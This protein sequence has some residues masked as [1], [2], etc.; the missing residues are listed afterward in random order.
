[1]T[2]G[3]RRES[4]TICGRDVRPSE[5]VD[6][7]LQV[8]ESYF[9]TA[10]SIPVHA[11]R[12]RR[13]GPT[14]LVTGAVH[15]DEINGTGIVRELML[16]EPFELQSGSLVLV[17]VVNLPGFERHSRYMPDRRDLNRS[18]PG[19]PEG[20]LARRYAH[21][22]FGELVR[23]CDYAIDLHTPAVRRTNFPN[24]RA[25]LKD[26]D[27]ARIAFAFG[28]GLVVNGK[29]PKGSL[30]REAGK[31]G[32]PTIVLEAGEALKFEPTVIEVGVQGVR[33][34]LIEL[35]MVEGTPLRPL[36]QARV[37]KAT[38]VRAATGGLLQLHVGPGDLVDEGQPVA[39][40]TDLLGGE[41]DVLEAPVDGVIMGLTTLPAVAPGDPV[42]HV[43]VPRDGLASIREAIKASD[44]SLLQ[45][46]HQDLSTNVVVSEPE[47]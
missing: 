27:V 33:N 6:I 46:V 14:V 17:P 21:V 22:L 8:A 31:I 15:G 35:G 12:G 2:S 45:R 1:M 40:T 13:P 9:G 16:H 28:S 4:L 37:D 32:C 39:T 42:C 41:S 36:Y 38:W 25:N 24:V 3:A 43:A 29:G 18:F 19:S 34:V 5:R 23:K 30:R 11:W 44:E 10:R 7:S 47:S 20:S 26:Q